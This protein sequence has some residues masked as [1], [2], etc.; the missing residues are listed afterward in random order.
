MKIRITE[1]AK[2]RA[3]ERGTDEKEIGMVLSGGQ[4]IPLKKGRKYKEKVFVYNKEWMGKM[5]PQ[6]NVKVVYV[7]ENDQIIV[8]TVKV[9]YGE[10]R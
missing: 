5:Y 1:H 9:S 6:K 3:I 2:D 4:E 7:E 10:W 8:I